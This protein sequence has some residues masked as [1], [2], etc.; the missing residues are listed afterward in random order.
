MIRYSAPKEET[1]AILS[2]VN[3]EV[4]TKFGELLTPSPEAARGRAGPLRFRWG[5]K[6][7][8]IFGEEMMPRI[9]HN[10]VK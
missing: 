5:E 1:V 3:G 6:I 8:W 4:A 7:F 10:F 2:G 9:R